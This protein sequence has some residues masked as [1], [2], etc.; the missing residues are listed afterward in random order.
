RF[1]AAQALTAAGRV[2]PDGEPGAGRAIVEDNGVSQGAGEG[3]LARG[4]GHTCESSAAVSGN[5][6]TG[7]VDR[8]LIAASRIVVR[9]DD[10]IR[11]IWISPSECFRLGNV[12]R[13]LG[14]GDQVDV[15]CAEGQ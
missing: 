11:V 5:R 4:V 2:E 7:N 6:R 15:R 8:I 12:G 9:D 14:A 3:A 1:V 10:L 13:S